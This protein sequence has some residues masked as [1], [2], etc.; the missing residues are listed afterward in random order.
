MVNCSFVT[1]LIIAG[2]RRDVEKFRNYLPPLRLWLVSSLLPFKIGETQTIAKTV[3]DENLT[4]S[5]IKKNKKA[6][7]FLG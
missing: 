6:G 3:Q 7:R 5:K 4:L 1:L 2:K